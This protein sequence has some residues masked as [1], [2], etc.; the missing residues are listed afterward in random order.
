MPIALLPTCRSVQALLIA[1]VV[2]AC[3]SKAPPASGPAPAGSGGSGGGGGATTGNAGSGGD[4]AIAAPDAGAPTA[5]PV[6]GT[7]MDAAAASGW[8]ASSAAVDGAGSSGEGAT[9]M[10]SDGGPQPSYEGEIPVYYGADPDPVVK[11]QCPEDP[12]AGWTEY[13]DTFHVERPYTVPINTRFSIIGGIYSLWVFPNDGPHSPIAH[14]KGPR[15]E[16]TYGGLHDK[17]NLVTDNSV[18]KGIAYFTSG[19]RMWSADMRLEASAEGSIVM[20]IHTTAA[21]IGPIYM[22]FTGGNLTHNLKTAVSGSSV[23]GGLVNTWFNLKVAFNAA[24]LQ[25]QLYINNCLKATVTGPRGD[26]HFYFK[27]GVYGCRHPEGCREHLKNIHLY[28]K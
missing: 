3:S 9:P 19:A 14:G 15:T 7:K 24:T 23:P 22:G 26:G 10:G 27:N 5:D 25:S 13:Q 11:M 2:T 28:A 8:D 6:A 20:Q 16:A 17:A 12:T 1:L 18:S 4:P 21:G